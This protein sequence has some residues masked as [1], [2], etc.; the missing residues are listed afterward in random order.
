M[1]YH[2]VK[3]ERAYAIPHPFLV[4]LSYLDVT[5][6][7]IQMPVMDRRLEESLFS[8]RARRPD[9]IS[10][11]I[12]RQQLRD[13]LTSPPEIN[14]YYSKYRFFDLFMVPSQRVM[15]H[16]LTLA[17]CDRVVRSLNSR[18]TDVRIYLRPC[19]GVDGELFDEVADYFCYNHSISGNIDL[20]F[21]DFRLSREILNAPQHIEFVDIDWLRG[22]F[23]GLRN[24]EDLKTIKAQVE[25]QVQE[26][27]AAERK[28]WR[29]KSFVTSSQ[30]EGCVCCGRSQMTA[31]E[32][33]HSIRSFD[34]RGG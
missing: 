8:S 12:T 26:G 11:Q 3:N 24:E 16:N 23:D 15:I 28:I 14:T 30:I 25:D 31:R 21:G 34:G 22:K 6:L 32:V 17:S 13:A 7:C 18:T 5:H 29:R 10:W 9:P 27:T 20:S 1:D 4:Y 19:A 33:C 2:M